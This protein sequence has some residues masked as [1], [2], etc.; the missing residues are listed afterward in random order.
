MN[1][2]KPHAIS[3]IAQQANR[4]FLELQSI[5]GI[6]SSQAVLQMARKLN[7]CID[8]ILQANTLDLELSRE[9]AVPELMI[10]WSSK[11]ARFA[12]WAI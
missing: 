12:C 7:E 10:D 5:K 3:Q 1:D 11:K 4:A 2:H 9:M 6:E 8:D